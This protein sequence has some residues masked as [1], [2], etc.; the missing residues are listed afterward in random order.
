M[1]ACRKRIFAL[2][3]KINYMKRSSMYSLVMTHRAHILFM[4]GR[5]LKNQPPEGMT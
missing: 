4:A 2:Q 1:A 5:V 3:S